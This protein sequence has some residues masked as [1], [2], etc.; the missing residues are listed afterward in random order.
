[1]GIG[2]TN[3]VVI[4]VFML[5]E[6]GIRIGIYIFFYISFDWNAEFVYVFF[7]I[8]FNI[9]STNKCCNAKSKE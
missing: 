3:R 6:L 2:N 5:K 7:P 8:C 1:M 4:I 9:N